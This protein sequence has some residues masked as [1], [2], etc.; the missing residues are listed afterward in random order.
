MVIQPIL[1]LSDDN[2]KNLNN[3]N[4][5]IKIIISLKK[6]FRDKKTG[7]YSK[8]MWEYFMNGLTKKTTTPKTLVFTDINNLKIAN[9]FGEDIGDRYIRIVAGLIRLTT[10]EHKGD[11]AIRFGGDEV[12][13]VYNTVTGE[14]K[15]EMLMELKEMINKEA[16]IQLILTNIKNKYKLNLD[17]KLLKQLIT[18]F[19]IIDKAYTKS[20]QKF[21]VEFAEGHGTYLPEMDIKEFLDKIEKDMY[22]KKNIQKGITIESFNIKKVGIIENPS[23]NMISIFDIDENNNEDLSTLKTYSRVKYLTKRSNLSKHSRYSSKTNMEYDEKARIKDAIL[24]KNKNFFKQMSK[25]KLLDIFFTMKDEITIDKTTGF[26]KSEFARHMFDD[27]EHITAHVEGKHI[28]CLRLLGLK[29]VN[30]AQGHEE[31]DSLLRAGAI[32]VKTF[33]NESN[34]ENEPIYIKAGAG[35]FIVIHDKEVKKRE[36]EKIITDFNRTR[37]E[38]EYQIAMIHCTEFY[39]QSNF[40]TP[41]VLIKELNENLAD[42]EKQYKLNEATLILENSPTREVHGKWNSEKRGI[43]LCSKYLQDEKYYNLDKVVL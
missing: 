19:K 12:L 24:K 5:L 31:G 8:N 1:E 6:H 17:E 27:K 3:T 14:D 36:L 38:G 29:A 37:Q 28:T 22:I 4:T 34:F 2:I 30:D 41:G 43:D 18:D 42:Q 32:K 10:E 9:S 7:L 25:D 21:E 40:N 16:H 11:Y 13:A 26:F 35:Q 39:D 15:I 23:S 20:N 33:F